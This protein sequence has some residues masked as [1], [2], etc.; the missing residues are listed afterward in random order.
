LW[1]L[2]NAGKMLKNFLV[3]L[4]GQFWRLDGD[5]QIPRFSGS[6]WER[7]MLI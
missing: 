4:F 2:G 3:N 6:A 5:W 7:G 1:Q